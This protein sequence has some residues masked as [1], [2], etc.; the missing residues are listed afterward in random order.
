M[1]VRELIEL[2]SDCPNPDAPVYLR[3]YYGDSI[4][5]ATKVTS[6]VY[7]DNEV[8]ITNEDLS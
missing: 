1:T 7:D 4:E 3:D 5:G 6:M 2:L 8:I